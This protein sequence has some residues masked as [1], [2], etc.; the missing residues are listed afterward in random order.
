MQN[1][2]TRVAE[3]NTS[4]SAVQD[5]LAKSAAPI[6]WDAELIDR[7]STW[8]GHVPFAH[9]IVAVTKPRVI[10]E[11]GTHAG[12]SYAAFCNAVVRENL[13]TKCFAI[14]TWEGD[15]HA[16]KYSEDVF[17]HLRE[18]HDATFKTFS[19]MLRSTF[20]EA[21]NQFDDGSIDLLHID[22]FHTYEAVS[23]DFE[24]WR[25]KLSDRGVVL[26]HDT[27]AH[28]E[29]FGV[30][31][32]W[33]EVTQRYPGFEFLHSH[34]LGVLALGT[35]LPETLRQLF[36]LNDADT[37]EFRTRFEFAG[38]R[39]ASESRSIQ[40]KKEHALQ[41]E[42]AN[43]Q[44]GLAIQNVKNDA[45]QAIKSVKDDAEKT[46]YLLREETS[47]IISSAQWDKEHMERRHS[48]E[49]AN[50]QNAFESLRKSTS[51]RITSPLR[52]LG[53]VVAKIRK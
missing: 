37:D 44:A 7:P 30:W 1:S 2:S 6:F 15:E 51:W 13:G 42:V 41:I 4:G 12:V 34:G 35:A 46:V 38:D 24:T 32:F 11:L 3:I 18:Y 53:N 14:D 27:N 23:H 17:W 47:R 25:P 33:D 16:G 22:G 50:L 20:D 45:A 19:T 29:G 31:K 43:G 10:V 36:A 39:W 49:I 40:Q 52:A 21:V 28:F 5:V 9:W 48:Q 26:F 8:F